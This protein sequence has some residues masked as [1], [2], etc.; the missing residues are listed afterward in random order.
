MRQLQ[1]WKLIQSFICHTTALQLIKCKWCFSML[2]N[3]FFWN[4]NVYL[5]I[6]SFSHAWSS[7][8]LL[9]SFYF[10]SFLPLFSCETG[11]M[12]PA[13][14]SLTPLLHFLFPLLC[15]F[16]IFEQLIKTH[17]DNMILF[18]NPYGKG[19]ERLIWPKCVSSRN[20]DLI[21]GQKKEKRL[22]LEV[23]ATSWYRNYFHFINNKAYSKGLIV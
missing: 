8:F 17:T 2:W 5:K 1:C 15:Q 14:S 16:P 23:R 10:F 9:I 3:I 22:T 12:P 20:V 4:F 13:A 21:W 18:F 7:S 19:G 11:S 6:Y